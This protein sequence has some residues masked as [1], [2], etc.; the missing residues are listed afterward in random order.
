MKKIYQRPIENPWNQYQ[1]IICRRRD[2][3]QRSSTVIWNKKIFKVTCKQ[4]HRKNFIIMKIVKKYIK[5]KHFLMQLFFLDKKTSLPLS[6]TLKMNL[7][8]KNLINPLFSILFSFN[9][10]IFGFSWE[11]FHAITFPSYPIEIRMVEYIFIEQCNPQSCFYMNYFFV[12]L[13]TFKI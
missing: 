3:A 5:E 9:K 11:T 6:Q 7:S 2:S 4:K 1:P 8:N 12:L 10:T 13:Y